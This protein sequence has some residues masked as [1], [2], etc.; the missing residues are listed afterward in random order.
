VAPPKKIRV[1]VADDEESV[2]RCYL[3]AFSAY[4]ERQRPSEL[5]DLDARLFSTVAIQTGTGVVFDVIGCSQGKDA[6]ALVRE[7]QA[8]ADAFDVVILD[9]RMPPGIDGVE[10]GESIRTLDPEA[11]L[12]IAT[13]FSDVPEEEIVRRLAPKSK[14]VYLTK[15][16]SFNKLV[17]DIIGRLNQPAGQ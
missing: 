4:Q 7:A 17:L 15:P 2:L 10:A 3:R 16:L 13:G 1:L 9:I 12:I 14:L 5:A 8:A 6:V 11:L